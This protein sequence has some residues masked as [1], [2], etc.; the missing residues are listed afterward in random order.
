M[1]TVLIGYK[2]YLWPYTLSRLERFVPEGIDVCLV[3]P[4]A[5][6]YELDR[7]AER[8]G[9]SRLV[10][11]ANNPSL[12][13]NLAVVRH[14]EADWLFKIDEDILVGEGFFA[15]LERGFVR[16]QAEGPYTPGFC[17]PVLN[18]NGFSYRLFVEA[19]GLEDEW[20]KEFGDLR[21]A[22]MGV[23]AYSDGQAARWLWERSVPFDEVSA[24][25]RRRPWA[26]SAVPHRFSIGAFVM[27]RAFWAETD[28]LEV[29]LSKP[30]VGAD[31]AFLCAQCVDL[32]RV[33]T[34]VHD[35]FAG[36][37]SFGPQESAMR[38]ALPQLADG[39]RITPAPA[40]S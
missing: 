1:L 35:V 12:A 23:P 16:T 30:G 32:S 2:P 19:L 5:E 38:A 3:S 17:A 13:Q 7:T 6:S 18:V 24:M 33:M 36:H 20:R 21:Q 26:A 22:C 15:G 11:E 29:D 25:F 8:L 4:A 31:E 39:L 37:F 10:T 27:Q 34:V 14:P 28:G 9:W 40:A